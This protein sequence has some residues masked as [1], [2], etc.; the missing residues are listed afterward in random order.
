[1]ATNSEP[2]TSEAASEVRIASLIVRIFFLG[3]DPCKKKGV[4]VA[5]QHTDSY[6]KIFCSCCVHCDTVITV[7]MPTDVDA[8]SGN[9]GR[10]R[11]F[12]SHYLPPTRSKVAK[13]LP[14]KVLI[15]EGIL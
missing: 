4:L 1:M 2:S 11:R 15:I 10:W 5:L 6:W 13:R 14:Q 12:F 9:G 8:I 3:V 7:C